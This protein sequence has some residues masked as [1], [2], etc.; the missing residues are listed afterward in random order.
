MEGA[1]HLTGLRRGKELEGLEGAFR[2]TMPS[3]LWDPSSKPLVMSVNTAFIL[4]AA[5]T[6]LNN[7]VG[8]EC[9]G[10]VK[11]DASAAERDATSPRAVLTVS[12]A[13]V[14]EPTREDG[15]RVA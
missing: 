9:P 5:C 10:D 13:R 3:G 6:C 8:G 2:A 11:S 14:E 7:C 15:G 4:F 1:T 12:S